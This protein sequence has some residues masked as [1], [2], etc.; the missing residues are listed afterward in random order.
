MKYRSVRHVGMDFLFAI[1]IN[2]PGSNFQHSQKPVFTHRLF[3]PALNLNIL[4]H[5][6]LR[7]E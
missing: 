7:S 1:I 2:K 6:L 5:N 3:L 4:N